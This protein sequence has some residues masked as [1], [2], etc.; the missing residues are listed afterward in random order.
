MT[1]DEKASRKAKLAIEVAP[2]QEMAATNVTIELRSLAVRIG[3]AHTKAETAF[4]NWMQ[5]AIELGNLLLAAKRAVGYGNWR[6]WVK[7]NTPMSVRTAQNYKRLA[8][9]V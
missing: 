4:E 2:P 9:R 5:S 3:A 8:E 1:F 7:P 6:A